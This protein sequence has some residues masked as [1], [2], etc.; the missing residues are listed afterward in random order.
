MSA[1]TTTAGKIKIGL[2]LDPRA[3]ELLR[4]MASGPRGLGSFI[5]G[6]ITAEAARRRGAP[7]AAQRYAQD[8]LDH[9]TEAVVTLDADRRVTGWNHAAEEMFLY[10]AAEAIGRH[11]DEVMP[12]DPI[13]ATLGEA[14]HALDTVGGWDG[15]L[16][17]HR[18]DGRDLP[19]ASTGV[20]VRDEAGQV[21][22]RI[23]VSRDNS[24]RWA[25]RQRI[26]TLQAAAA[27]LAETLDL[28]AVLERLLEYL[29]RLI[30]FDSA[31]VM[32]RVDE[33]TVAVAALRGYERW[34][35][36][37]VTAQI[38]FDR[39]DTPLIAR[40]LDDPRSILV[41]DTWEDADWAPR[42]G[43]EHVRCWLAVPLV[44]GGRVL[45]LY[46][47]D[48][49]EP[50]FFTEEHVRLAEALAPH[51]AVAIHNAQLYAAMKTGQAQLQQLSRR[52]VE[53]QEHERRALS[54]DLHDT[55]AQVLTALQ[56]GLGSLL[57]GPDLSDK[58]RGRVT[59]IL[60]MADA[61]SD[62]LHRLAV[63]LRPSALDRYGLLPAL[64]QLLTEFRKQTGQAVRFEAEGTDQLPVRLPG[65]V[66][67]ALYRIVQESLVN[68][69]RHAQAQTVSVG[70]RVAGDRVELTIEDDGRGFEVEPALQS[71]RLGLLGLRERAGMLGGRLEIDSRPGHGT[72]IR[73]RVPAP[74]AAPAAGLPAPVAAWA[75]TLAGGPVGLRAAVGDG[76][77]A[78]AAELARAK[79]LSDALI[80]LTAQ[81]AQCT[82]ADEILRLVLE[83]SV[84]ALGREAAQIVL[85]EADGWWVRY[86]T[87][88][89]ALVEH[90]TDAEAPAW[91]WA[92]R[93]RQVL[94]V[95]DTA[96]PG[97]DD[98]LR[99]AG[100]GIKS[101]ASIPLVAG[102]RFLGILGLAATAAVLPFHA[103]EVEFF[104]RLA[105]LV[106]LALENILLRDTTTRQRDELAAY[107][108][109]LQGVLVRLSDAEAQARD[110]I[111][112]APTAIYELDFSTNKIMSANDAMCEMSGYSRQELLAMSALDVIDAADRAR[113]AERQRRALAGE[114][115]DPTV[116]YAVRHKDGQMRYA[117]L[118]VRIV[119]HEDGHT[120]ALVIA[121]D[122]TERHRAAS[123]LD[124]ERE[125]LSRL[126]A[127]QDAVLDAIADGLVIYDGA[128]R[129]TRMNATAERALGYSPAQ[130]QVVVGALAERQGARLPDG[131]VYP[132]D[133]YPS[134]RALNGETV[135]NDVMVLRRGAETVWLSASAAPIIGPDG[136][137]RGAVA[138]FT[139]VTGLRET[140]Q[141]LEQ[142]NAE[143]EAAQEELAAQ[144]E[145]SERLAAELEV[146]LSSVADGLV[147]YDGVGRITR[148]N[149][150]AEEMLGFD[151][152]TR[153]LP[154]QQRVPSAAVG[155]HPDGA[156]YERHEYPTVRALAGEVVRHEELMMQLPGRSVEASW[157]SV[158]SGPICGPDG[159][160]AGAV[161][162]FTDVSEV[163]RLNDRLA[164][165]NAAL[166][167]MNR[168]LEAILAAVP[169]G[170]IVYDAA[171]N[172][173][174]ASEAARRMAGWRPESW[175]RPVDERVGASVE[176]GTLNGRPLDRD[177][178]PAMRALRGEALGGLELHCHFPDRPENDF[179]GMFAAGPIRGAD[180]QVTG[181]L[182]TWVDTSGL[183]E[184]NEQ[185]VDANTRL[186]AQAEQLQ[187]AA[188]FLE[189][190][191]RE[192]T[193]ELQAVGVA[194]RQQGQ[195]L[196][197]LHEIDRSILAAHATA[198]IAHCAIEK[199]LQATIAQ[200][201]TVVL[202]DWASGMGEIL[203]AVGPEGTHRRGGSRA[204]L[205]G[206]P[207]IERV[208]AGE[209][210]ILADMAQ[211]SEAELPT[212]AET[213]EA[214]LRSAA[215]LPL[216]AAGEVIGLLSVSLAQPGPLAPEL[217]AMAA[218]VAD[219]LAVA[220]H[221]ARL[222]EQLEVSHAQLGQREAALQTLSRRLV[223]RQEQERSYVA[224]R[225]YNEAAQVIAALK[226]QAARL[227]RAPELDVQSA[228]WLI[229]VAKNMDG[230]LVELHRLASD[231][232][233]AV[234]DRLGLDAAVQQ[235]ADE[236]A[237][238]HGVQVR[239]RV[240]Q[241]RE[242][243]LAPEIETCAYRVMQEALAN[244]EQHA[245]ATRVTVEVVRRPGVLRLS[246]ADDG[247]GFDV[248]AAEE[249]GALGVVG[250]RERAAA[251]RGT[252]HIDS[253]PG[254]GTTV[255]LEVPVE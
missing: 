214:G 181:G 65:D 206:Y 232:R 89:G 45:G 129:I 158:S 241:L 211:L 224:D 58:V 201:A 61:V 169:S 194:L 132:P 48:K 179:W 43:A 50:G 162:T 167:R 141:Q 88:P 108:E 82:N 243:R 177:D 96:A 183:R 13:G 110:L 116:A 53:T 74:Q 6:L 124:A 239:C 14:Y 67:T 7:G 245:R 139:D 250:M 240:Q 222:H 113:L 115:V 119:H 94:L 11:V 34:T 22:Y 173:V 238:K 163:H 68:V 190:R 100:L 144:R 32:L 35:D 90:Y 125:R 136:N 99:L 112:Y 21:L 210:V 157:V 33:N 120:S 15:E 57:R 47:I 148:M 37:A 5:D 246:V 118:N 52:L 152:H 75:D 247:A 217:V 123:A 146:I 8:V 207:S 91:L 71:G 205:S 242:V 221:N 166:G 62:E 143:L 229:D 237:E 155:L 23:G 12:R 218:H 44:A 31:N 134:R 160:V 182:V 18:R 27:A 150:A 39:G 40:M 131:R 168:D 51:A 19:V 197:L 244:V 41:P 121:H 170:L 127:E 87:P 109:E 191:V 189:E 154:F 174:R 107:V 104:N 16:I 83:R 209:V 49:A 204:P 111:R 226:W 199:L 106:S 97:L 80:D 77:L 186:E 223:E 130:G 122:L 30:P 102:E 26:D 69:A 72:I 220:L 95:D 126:A 98:D 254:A 193:A 236:F 79:A 92:E 24:E 60:G 249:R 234:L 185:L 137:P 59:D 2:A 196:E 151:P 55:A 128:G 149:A 192:R 202:T 147:V 212:R 161:T 142:I 188:V 165:V 178:Y 28:N 10:T 228:A 84:A 175:G 103:S 42:A 25:A 180:G 1:R 248:P 219:S 159:R 56:L 203:A 9:V 38:R 164:A 54:R 140:Q 81:M 227:G 156:P 225:L 66:E 78:R 70:F 235:Y 135:V 213:L 36:A 187:H 17:V 216:V 215:L 4:E 251:L 198:D 29:A 153:G 230:A 73:A 145:Q 133:R 63:N 233:P 117:A 93:T 105:T 176:L 195:R 101:Y 138:T 252:L 200:R 184:A 171:G 114:L 46:S 64:E 76:A 208:R 3:Y 20:V 231:L 86:S 253:R 172:T 85:R 255:V